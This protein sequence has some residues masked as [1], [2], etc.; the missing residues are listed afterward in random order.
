MIGH[1]PRRENV[2][3]SQMLDRGETLYGALAEKHEA[4]S[5]WERVRFEVW[6]DPDKSVASDKRH[7]AEW[8]GGQYV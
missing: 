8:R 6:C 7:E 5:L 3:I 4:D 2:A 1:L